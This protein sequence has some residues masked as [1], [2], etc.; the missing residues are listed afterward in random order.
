MTVVHLLG[1]FHEAIDLSA[2]MTSS[3]LPVSSDT[4]NEFRTWDKIHNGLS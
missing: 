4:T 3:L 2:P 1:D